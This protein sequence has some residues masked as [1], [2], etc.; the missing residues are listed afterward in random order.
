MPENFRIIL[1]GNVV[2]HHNIVDDLK[3][4][5]ILRY[6]PQDKAKEKEFPHKDVIFWKPHQGCLPLIAPNMNFL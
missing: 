6:R 3:Y 2:E 4:R 1:R 5:Q